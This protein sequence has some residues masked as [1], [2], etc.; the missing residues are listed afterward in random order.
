MSDTA[1]RVE[2]LSKLYRIGER[3]PYK[4]L[5]DTITDA[6]YAPFR[7]VASALNGRRSA[8]GS[9]SSDNYIWALKDVSFEVKQGE[10][11]G[12]IGHNGAGK[13]TLLKILSR[14]TVPTEGEV[15]ICGRVGSLLEVGTGFNPELTGRENIYLNG[16]ILGMKKA[17]IHFNFD[18]I[19][20]F[21]E[22]EKFIEIPVKRY[23]TGMYM[24]LAFAVAAHLQPAILLVDEVLAVGDVAFQKKCLGKMGD[25]AKEGRT[26]LLVSHNMTAIR[27]LCERTLWI[28]RGRV[29]V[30]GPT[31]EVVERYE[32]NRVGKAPIRG[33]VAQRRD[34]PT[35]T[36]KF[37]IS[38]VEMLNIHGQLTGVFKHGETIVLLVQLSGKS[39]SNRNSVEFRIFGEVGD[40]LK[41]IRFIAVGAS[42]PFHGIYFGDETKKVRIDIGPLTLSN[43]KYTIS[44]SMISGNTRVDTWDDACSFSVVDCQPFARG[45]YISATGCVISHSFAALE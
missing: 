23:S 30:D 44:L 25:V 37:H 6:M 20:A 35:Q 31:N 19:V 45:H 40:P 26:V 7:A 39:S 43:G 9:Q 14:I 42:G 32:D 41:T 21:A 18:Q 33:H 38:C 36:S 22:L 27:A 17:E 10:V 3:E 24:R 29:I 34:Y 2:N 11:V 1:I 5:R 16:A 8:V 15:D 13:S 12:V 4:A 28:D